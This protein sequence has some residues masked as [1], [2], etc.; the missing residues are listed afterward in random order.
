MIKAKHKFI[1]FIDQRD[2]VCCFCEHPASYRFEEQNSGMYTDMCQSCKN[3]RVTQ[4]NSPVSVRIGE[5]YDVDIEGY[6]SES[7]MRVINQNVSL[8]TCYQSGS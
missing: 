5:Q 6:F 2:N 3:T 7:A 4:N 8:Q 1:R